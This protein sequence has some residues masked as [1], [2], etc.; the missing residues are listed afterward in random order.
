MLVPTIANFPDN[1]AR[2]Q[3]NLCAQQASQLRA[4]DLLMLGL[5]LGSIA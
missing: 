1:L 3:F 4:D 5:G 2:E